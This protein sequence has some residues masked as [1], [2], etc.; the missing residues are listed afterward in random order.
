MNDLGSGAGKEEFGPFKP[1]CDDGPIHYLVL[2]VFNGNNFDDVHIYSI[3]IERDFKKI[4]CLQNSNLLKPKIF[5]NERID[6]SYKCYY[7]NSFKRLIELGLIKE[8]L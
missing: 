7:R 4:I 8:E 5:G 2:V 3:D 6:G 1:I